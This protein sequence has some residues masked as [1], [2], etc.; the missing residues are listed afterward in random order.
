M[1]LLIIAMFLSLERNKVHILYQANRTEGRYLLHHSDVPE[2]ERKKVHMYTFHIGTD[3]KVRY[4]FFIMAM[5]LSLERKKRSI[6]DRLCTS[7]TLRP[8]SR[9][10]CVVPSP[11]HPIPSN[12]KKQQK[13]VDQRQNS[14]P[15]ILRAINKMSLLC[16]LH[17]H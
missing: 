16:A 6:L 11:F 8:S 5:F 17:R 13:G 14:V 3:C 2:L 12:H 9:A 15:I 1:Y 10:A 4:T 7:S